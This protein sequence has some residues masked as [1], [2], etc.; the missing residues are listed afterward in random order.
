M[1]NIQG[2]RS[3][4][5]IARDVLTD[6]SDIVRGE[7]RLAQAEIREKAGKAG[8]AGG[9]MGAAA[10]CGLLASACLV[11]C[12]IAALALVMA[13]WLAALVMC[14]LLGGGAV[15]LFALGRTR[16]K[17]IDPVPGRTVETAKDTL[18]WARHR[19]T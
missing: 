6:V 3:P 16:F 19:T 9:M 8:K 4:G 1:A 12:C 7:I 18:R 10:L 14:V 15:A 5:D 2:E 13:V 11:A 17:Q